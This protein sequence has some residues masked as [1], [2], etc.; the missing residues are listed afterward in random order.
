MIKKTFF[1]L[2]VFLSTSIYG[3]FLNQE[4]EGDPATRLFSSYQDRIFQIRVINEFTGQK[5]AIG[6]GF[7]IGEDNL[8]ATNYHVISEVLQKDNHRLE[9][10]DYQDEVGDLEL[11][12]VDVVHDLALLKSAKPLGTPFTL[13]DI[14]RQG[15]ALYALGNPYDLGFIIIDG[16]N[17]GLLRRSSRARILFSGSLNSGMSGGPTL[18]ARGEVVG[19]NVAYLSSGNQISFIIPSQ[20]LSA[21]LEEKDKQKDL[22]ETIATQI[23]NDNDAYYL[24]HLDKPWQKGNIGQYQIPLSM[25]DDVRCW[26]SSPTPNLDDLIS[27]QSISCFN[28]RSTFINE[29]VE[30]G[31]FAYTYDIIYAREPLLKSRFY[32]LYSNAYEINF[33]RRP[34]RDYD[35]VHCKSNFLDLSGQTFKATLCR[36]A[37]K[38]FYKNETAIE[39]IRF[40]A[41]SLE[42]AQEGFLIK[43][44]L[45]G[46]QKEL[47]DAVIKHIL[48]QITWQD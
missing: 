13:A 22:N 34:R 38:N 15:Q 41:A 7:I 28:D 11:L 47:A 32:R 4:E 31:Q 24:P 43:I 6:S 10:L 17:N 20:Y 33:S 26:D 5:T 8:I 2:L 27:I 30:I 1:L 23:F 19:V 44:A 46:V 25:S 18:N 37:S 40:I 21:L 35:D 9:Y 42:Q 29:R 36:R 48:E 45:N 39:D 12:A 14:P 3:Q 16:I